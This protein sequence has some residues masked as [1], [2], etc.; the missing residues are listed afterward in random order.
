MIGNSSRS[1]SFFA[2]CA[3][4]LLHKRIPHCRPAFRFVTAEMSGKLG[5][6]MHSSSALLTQSGISLPE[7]IR[8]TWWD[9]VVPAVL[10]PLGSKNATVTV[11]LGVSGGC[12]SVALL[13][14]LCDCFRPKDES[15]HGCDADYHRLRWNLHAVHFDHQ[16]RGAE[17][18]DD[19][20]L[21]VQLC[22][23]R[24]IPIHCYFWQDNNINNN[25]QF[26]KSNTFSQDSARQ[27]RRST[28][29]QLL[30][31]EMRTVN[32]ESILSS[33]PSIGLLVTAHHK[34]DSDETLLLKL[35]RGVHV[36]N[37]S[38]LSPVKLDRS[39]DESI[40][41]KND[42][43]NTHDKGDNVSTEANLFWVRPL[44]HVRKS[45][46]VDY[47]KSQSYTWREDASNQSDKYLRN[48][49]RNELIPLLQ[50]LAG[51]SDALE[52]RLENLS[53]QAQAIRKDLDD[54]AMLCMS[55]DMFILPPLQ[56]SFDLA[57]KEALN[58]WITNGTNGRQF[59]YEQT[60]KI[61]QQIENYPNNK[62]WSLDIGEN[63]KVIRRGMVLYLELD[64]NQ[65]ARQQECL[66]MVVP[67]RYAG[68]SIDRVDEN[69]GSSRIPIQLPPDVRQPFQFVL[70][71]VGDQGWF[72]TPP[73]R[74][75]N[76]PLKATEFLRGQQ[77]P[78]H[79][80]PLAPII[81]MVNY[82]E[83]APMLLAVYVAT[84]NKWIVDAMYHTL[85]V[86]DERVEQN[87]TIYL[88]IEQP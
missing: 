66:D 58:L 83:E 74:K 35:L 21:V 52:R 24:N 9:E 54:R 51:G 41:I 29:R 80:R 56:T 45:A 40:N 3:G 73:W 60:R 88:T 67:W 4:V 39:D 25:T 82:N 81:T 70:S 15:D 19:R 79:L 68:D 22:Q 17:S 26:Q 47:M 50:D 59:A 87:R 27:W 44:V 7:T 8:K 16:Q 23:T 55:K 48:R 57:V 69:V 49:V 12:D 31:D 38:G 2:T 36:S 13:H 63:W 14:I 34:D 62:V 46:I 28:M 43:C 18:D 77:V 33:M 72:F 6:M 53:E 37:L 5:Q 71:T 42:P 85:D 84:T 78:L 20:D 65:H 61:C 1:S 10:A 75:G 32:T 30:R 11:V 76:R 64:G 86:T